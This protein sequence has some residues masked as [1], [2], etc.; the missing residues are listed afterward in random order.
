E[1]GNNDIDIFIG[2]ENNMCELNNT[3]VLIS[4]YKIGD[5]SEGILALVGPVR[6]DYAKVISNLEYFSNTLAQILSDIVEKNKE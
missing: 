5:Y 2:K 4:K 6:M 3:A 1:Q